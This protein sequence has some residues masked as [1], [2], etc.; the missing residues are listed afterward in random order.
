MRLTWGK[1][2]KQQNW[3]YWQDLE[4]LQ[5]DQFFTQGMLGD[6]WAVTSEE[7]VFNLVWTYNIKAL[8]GCKKKRCT[9]GGS[10][11]SGMV[12]ILDKTY[13]N[14]VKQ[15]SSHLF[16]AI[17]AAEYLLIYGTNVLN[18]FAKA[19]LLKQGFFI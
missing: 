19:L 18:A 10:P 13:A 4:F 8:D 12:C 6:P 5:L 15:T 16:H 3:H 14:C 9:C 2:L 7:A 17:S 1:L 11:Q